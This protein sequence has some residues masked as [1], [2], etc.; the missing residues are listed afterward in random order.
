MK[1]KIE[2]EINLF[3]FAGG[4]FR[5]KYQ[6]RCADPGWFNGAVVLALSPRTRAHARATA[7]LKVSI[8]LRW[9]VGGKTKN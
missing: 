7:A 2:G 1:L 6:E 3:S 8:K 4:A 5:K 9:R